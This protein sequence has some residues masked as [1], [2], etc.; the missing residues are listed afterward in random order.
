MIENSN[1]LICYL[2]RRMPQIRETS[3]FVAKIRKGYEFHISLKSLLQL[4]KREMNGPDHRKKVQTLK[5][6]MYY[7]KHQRHKNRSQSADRVRR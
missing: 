4:R 7:G 2:C 5:G 3:V 1:P 6:E